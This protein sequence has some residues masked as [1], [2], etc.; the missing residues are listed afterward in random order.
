MCW[1]E[2]NDSQG[3]IH[4]LSFFFAPAFANEHEHLLGPEAG[5]GT[6]KI[7]VRCLGYMALDYQKLKASSPVLQVGISCT[8]LSQLLDNLYKSSLLPC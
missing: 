6:D 2:K 8:F 5:H 4:V 7:S 1:T 3:K